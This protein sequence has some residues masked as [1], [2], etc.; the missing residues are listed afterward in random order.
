MTMRI[1]IDVQSTVGKPT[2]IGQY[3]AKLLAALR[4]V[5]PEHEY[6][7][8]AW[9]KDPVMR[10]Y[11]RILWQQGLA[12]RRAQVAQP[13]LLHIPGFD[14]PWWKPCPVVLTCHDLI[15]MLFPQNLPPAARF[16]WSRWLPFSVRFAD[17][18]IADSLATRRD[19]VRLL[20]IDEQRIYVVPLGVD[21]RF[22]PQ[23]DAEVAR[24]QER[25]HLPPKFVLFVGTLEPR[26]GI[27]TLIEAFAAVR[28][29]QPALDLVIAGK[30]GWYWRQLL[31]RI[32]ALGLE[33][34]VHVLDYVPEADLVALYSAATVFALP[35]RYEGFGLPV[36]EAMASG[37]PVITT[38]SSSLPEVTGDAGLLVPPDDV[39]ALAAAIIAVV[40]QPNLQVALRERGIERA[41]QFTWERTARAT[42]RIYEQVLHARLY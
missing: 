2:G 15:G 7:E 18:I 22:R 42:L 27:D 13:E 40:D 31:Q 21:Q 12:P 26:K 11:N 38:H 17:A 3:T 29:S 16:Y 36:L 8:I 5:A 33:A 28:Q 20:A 39:G 37:A 30:R 25:Y 9:G 10:L 1:A 35:S 23:N 19:I 34:N 41:R 4:H 32:A 6:V 24:I 14:A